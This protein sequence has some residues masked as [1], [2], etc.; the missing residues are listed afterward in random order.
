[1][2]LPH[3]PERYRPM[4]ITVVVPC[5]LELYMFRIISDLGMGLYPPRVR[6]DVDVGPRGNSLI[7]FGSQ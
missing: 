7:A 5:W 3:N 2:G 4:G 6:R 1:M